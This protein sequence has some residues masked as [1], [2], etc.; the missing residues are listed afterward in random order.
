MKRSAATVT[1]R[2]L[3]NRKHECAWH[4]T[5]KRQPIVKWRRDF[6]GVKPTRRTRNATIVTRTTRG[7][8]P[9]SSSSTARH[10]ITHSRISHFGMLTNQCNATVV[11]CRALNFATPPHAVSIVIRR[12][13]RIKDVS[14]RRA[15][16]VMAKPHGRALSRSTTT[17]PS[18]R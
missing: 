12:L 5:K 11:T 3:D 17:R 15:T 18:S 4:V 1:S 9:T 16:V 8:T 13:T 6:M 7:E 10:S 14:G 2:S